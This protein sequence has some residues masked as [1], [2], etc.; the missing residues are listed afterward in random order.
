M[1][2]PSDPPASNPRFVGWKSLDGIRP[3]VRDDSVAEPSHSDKL[4]HQVQ[5]SPIFWQECDPQISL[6]HLGIEEIGCQ[7]F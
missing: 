2:S 4:L 6:E 3:P 1:E 7:R 5:A